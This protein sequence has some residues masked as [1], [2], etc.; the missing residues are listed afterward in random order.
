MLNCVGLIASA[1][2]VHKRES[3]CLN[4]GGKLQR[5]IYFGLETFTVLLIYF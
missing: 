1:K 4:H 3:E 5:A 2:S